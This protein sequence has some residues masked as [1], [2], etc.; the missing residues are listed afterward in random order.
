M[1]LDSA[2]ICPDYSYQLLGEEFEVNLSKLQTEFQASGMEG[3]VIDFPRRS[4]SPLID[5]ESEE[6]NKEPP[7]HESRSTT[8]EVYQTREELMKRTT[9]ERDSGKEN[10]KGGEFSK[11]PVADVD[12]ASTPP[13]PIISRKR[14]LFLQRSPLSGAR[15]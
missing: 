9:S 12:L 2:S 14:P 10:S 3:L 8:G 15:S 11:V 5:W 13:S 6:E 1:R 4:P 7:E